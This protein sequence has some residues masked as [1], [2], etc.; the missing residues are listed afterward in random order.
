M[1]RQVPD[2]AQGELQG[3]ISSARAVAMILSPLVMTS[4]FALFTSAA[5][6]VYMPGAAFLLS[7]GLMVVCG[8]VFVA[9]PRGHRHRLS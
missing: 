5:A 3:S 9:S 8:L 1:S 7:M 2:D 4:V 6:P